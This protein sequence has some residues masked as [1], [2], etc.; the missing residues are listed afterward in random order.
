MNDK[1]LFIFSV[2][3]ALVWSGDTK[4]QLLK[5]RLAQGDQEVVKEFV[6]IARPGDHIILS[7]GEMVVKSR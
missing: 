1:Y 4:E 6:T 5:R 7:S 2:N 3:G